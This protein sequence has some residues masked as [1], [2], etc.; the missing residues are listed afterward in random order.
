MCNCVFV[1]VVCVRAR[2]LCVHSSKTPKLTVRIRFA[3]GREYL[4][5]HWYGCRVA[6]V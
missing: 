3:G 2:V 1:C 6:I 4:N 5:N